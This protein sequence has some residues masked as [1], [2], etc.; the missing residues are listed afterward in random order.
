M[1][2]QAVLVLKKEIA[3]LNCIRDKNQGLYTLVNEPV[4]QVDDAGPP[5]ALDLPSPPPEVSF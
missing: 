1:Q 2:Q 5:H 3:E 4:E